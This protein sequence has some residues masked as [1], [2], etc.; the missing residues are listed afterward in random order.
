MK[1]DLT[2]KVTIED[3]AN[4]S[5]CVLLFNGD[6]DKYGNVTDLNLSAASFLGF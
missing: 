5:Q 6:E 3:W 2:K 4:S 1:Y